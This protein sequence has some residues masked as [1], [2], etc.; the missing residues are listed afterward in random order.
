MHTVSEWTLQTAG[1]RG[2]ESEDFTGFGL[3]LRLGLRRDRVMIA[4]WL[5]LLTAMAYASA[6]TTPTLFD[7]EESRVLLATSLNSQT[8]VVALYGPILDVTSVG[9]IAMAKM[10][11]LYALAPAILMVILVRRHTRT[12]E[13]SGRAELVGAGVIGRGS[14]LAAAVGQALAVSAM[15]G[16][17]VST[18]DILGGL[19]VLGSIWF[20]LAWVGTGAVATGVAAVAVQLSPSSR[21]CASIA[22]AVLGVCYLVRAVGDASGWTWLSWVSPLGW[23]TQL[24]AWQDPRAW[25]VALYAGLSVALLNV[26]W[27]LRSRRDLGSGIIAPR[28]G[29]TGSSIASPL[30]L[31]ARTQRTSLALWSVS[32]AGV[33]VLFG[34][35]SPGLD[36]MM[37]RAG[38]VEILDRLGGAMIAAVLS[39]VAI[40]ISSYSII[41]VNQVAADETSDRAELVLSTAASRRSWFLATVATAGLGGVWLLSLTGI[42][43]WVGYGLAGGQSAWRAL[44]AALTWIPVVWTVAGVGLVGYGLRA[45]WAVFGWVALGLS[46]LVTLVGELAAFPGWV[47][48]L[49]PYSLI[50]RYPVEEVDWVVEIALVAVTG[51]LVAAAWLRFRSRDIG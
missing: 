10:T 41:V 1:P 36:D 29:P 23:N 8:A 38:G 30:G 11:V 27:V 12:E 46:M 31:M 7:S 37:R 20:G 17:L 22:A 5:V 3:L 24:S 15:L 6:A 28:P 4:V 48:N 42:G 14:P 51:A 34:V 13:E 39:V 40:V 33:A 43:L 16:L 26:A 45:S 19:P 21:T 50:A 44:P 32:V 35:I 47:V 25:V 49:S 18:A 9:E 2:T